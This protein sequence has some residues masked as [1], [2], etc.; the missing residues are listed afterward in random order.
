MDICHLNINVY[1]KSKNVHK[2]VIF[3]K[4]IKNNHL[5][6]NVNLDMY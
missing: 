4:L 1:K 6:L 2:I 5:V 3:V